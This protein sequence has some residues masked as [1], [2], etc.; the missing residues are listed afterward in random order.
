M[1]FDSP[2]LPILSN[3]VPN[4]DGMLETLTR[5][6]Q[7]MRRLDAAAERLAQEL[8]ALNGSAL[9]KTLRSLQTTVN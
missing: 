6:E 7:T 9:L 4:R 8:E 5:F 3:S 2:A 1:P